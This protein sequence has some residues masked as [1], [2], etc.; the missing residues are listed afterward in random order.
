MKITDFN[1]FD[2][3]LIGVALFSMIMAF[4][5]GLI[6][7]IFGLIGFI[8]GF[9]IAAWTYPDAADLLR[10]CRIKMSIPTA[11]IIAFVLVVI[12]VALL[13]DVAGRLLQRFLRRVGLGLFD[14]VL[15]MAFG[16]ARGCLIGLALLMVAT[17]VAPQSQMIAN[18]VLSPYLFAVSHDVSFLVPQYLQDLMWSGANDFKHGT[19][20]WINPR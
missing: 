8:G 14:R 16:F 19:P 10:Q 18:S 15:G 1:Y 5:R 6:R 4:R 9:Q 11:R 17:T 13:M 20:A 3:F 2:W 12:V 7:A